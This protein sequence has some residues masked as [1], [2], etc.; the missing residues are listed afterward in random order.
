MTICNSF[1][2][3]I[4][5]WFHILDSPAAPDI[6][7]WFEL[8][9]RIHG[10]VEKIL[11]MLD[12]FCVKATLFWLGWAAERHKNL[13]RRCYD[14]GHE[15][16]SHGYGHV[17]A[18]KVGREAFREDITRGKKILED[19]IGERVLGFRAAGFGITD[20]ATWA[21][22]VIKRSGYA[23]DSSIF[24]AS[25]GHGGLLD[26]RLGPNVIHTEAGPL[27]EVPMSAVKMFGRRVILFGGGYLRIAPKWLIRWGAKKLCET[28]QPLIV[29]VHPREI[30]PEHP[31]LPLSPIRRF[32]CY[33]N[34]KSTMPKLRWLCK[35]YEF[36]PTRELVKNI[37]YGGKRP[38]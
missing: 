9:S 34:L 8:E 11:T 7:Q 21:F 17:L 3:D 6:E 19:I 15:I 25:R 1:T 38:K 20:E 26:S 12:S 31:H 29:Y 18:Y 13:V 33:V 4:E 23:Y 24:P 32:K 10:N 14:A 22:E 36:V 28:D 27:P 30:D 37:F 35:N 2:V 16:A 5:D